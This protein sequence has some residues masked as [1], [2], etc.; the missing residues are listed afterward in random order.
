MDKNKFKSLD[1]D[2]KIKLYKAHKISKNI[3]SILEISADNL[4]AI[5]NNEKVDLI[6]YSFPCQD[7]SVAGSFYGFNKG[8]SKNSNTRSSLLWE[9]G[10]ILTELKVKNKLPKFLLLE[11]V[12]NMISSRHM[13]EYI[14]WKKYLFKLGYKT[15]TYKHSAYDHGIPQIRKRVYAISILDSDLPF[16]KEEY[17]IKECNKMPNKLEK[18]ESIKKKELKDIIKQNYSIEKY[19]EEALKATPNRTISRQR[20]FYE[21]FIL[22]DFKKH[23]YARTLT[24]RQDRHPNAGVIDLRGSEIECKD[25]SKAKYRFLTTR[26]AYLLMGFDEKDYDRVKKQNIKEPKLYQQAGNSIVVNAI[27]PVIKKIQELN[28]E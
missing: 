28:N 14:K 26:E 17:E 13:P 23:K 10:R 25:L 21:N 8:M 6:T 2:K 16:D 3:G 9:I 5:T 4:L 11:N 22:N 18:E 27:I 24:T 1:K 20:M 12:P 7:L 15:K 19:K